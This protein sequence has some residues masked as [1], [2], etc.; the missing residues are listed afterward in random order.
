MRIEM[1]HTVVDKFISSSSDDYDND[2]DFIQQIVKG[3]YTSHSSMLNGIV[4]SD[5]ATSDFL[6]MRSAVGV[7]LDAATFSDFSA[8]DQ[9]IYR[10]TVWN[11]D[12]QYVDYREEVINLDING[13]FRTVDYIRRLIRHS[14]STDS[15]GN[16]WGD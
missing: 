3:G 7:V 8:A 5:G 2:S 10:T 16:N 11:N 6:T 13:P 12:D 14:S 15:D 1:A 9:S 4:D